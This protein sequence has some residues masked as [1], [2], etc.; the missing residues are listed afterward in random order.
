[1]YIPRSG[2]NCSI[3]ESVQREGRTQSKC[4]VAPIDCLHEG[5]A[6]LG[7]ILRRHGISTRCHM[8]YNM[9]HVIVI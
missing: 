1:M 8:G 4:A 2:K 7:A 5:I 9:K 6:V 3:H